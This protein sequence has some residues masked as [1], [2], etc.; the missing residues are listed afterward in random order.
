[1]LRESKSRLLS[2]TN[3]LKVS[4]VLM[5]IMMIGCGKSDK[6]RVDNFLDDYEEV[7]EQWEASI[8]DG[9]FTEDDSDEMNKTLEEMGEEAKELQNVTKWNKKQQEKY[10]K[11]SERIMDAVFKSMNIPGGFSF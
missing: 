8:A 4:V 9:E 6:Q 1:M 10:A 7:V 5:A 2:G 11:L 3:I